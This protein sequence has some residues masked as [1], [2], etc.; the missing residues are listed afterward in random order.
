MDEFFSRIAA[1]KRLGCSKE[2]ILKL[3]H[4]GVIDSMRKENGGC[5]CQQFGGFMRS[6]LMEDVSH[7]RLLLQR[8]F[9]L[10]SEYLF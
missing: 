5:F 3:L 2:T 6:F 7:P 9:E 4:S 1:Q 10:N 8:F